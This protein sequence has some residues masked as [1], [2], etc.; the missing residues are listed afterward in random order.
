MALPTSRETDKALVG[1]AELWVAPLSS[2]PADFDSYI[3]LSTG[4]PQ[5]SSF[6]SLGMLDDAD[7]EIPQTVENEA[8]F[9]NHIG[10]TIATDV[11][12]PVLNVSINLLSF[13]DRE[14]LKFVTGEG[15][16]T[17]HAYFVKVWKD[18][19]TTGAH[20]Y[21]FAFIPKAKFARSY[22][23]SIKKSG[24]ITISGLTLKASIVDNFEAAPNLYTWYFWDSGSSAYVALTS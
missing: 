5:G 3:N 9:K 22:T 14:I 2:T 1:G 20:P 18:R 7:F 17:N 11:G 10:E 24:V 13:K 8:E 4:H 16:D 21:A 23:V 15:I 6:Y 19:D 12:N